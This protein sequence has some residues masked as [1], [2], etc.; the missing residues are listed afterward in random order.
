MHPHRYELWI[1]HVSLKPS[2][3]ELDN[4]NMSAKW[5]HIATMSIAFAIVV[6]ACS[7]SGTSPEAVFEA[8]WQCDVQRQTFASLS[9]LDAELDSRLTEAGM[10]MQGYE[11][12]KEMLSTSEGL[13]QD[14]ATEY[15]AYCLS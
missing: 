1:H 14:V 11:T 9:D 7:S 6:S 12:F 8:R 2:I 4:L 3:E 10:T 13:R 15:E 5:S